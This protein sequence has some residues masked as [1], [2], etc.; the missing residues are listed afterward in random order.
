MLSRSPNPRPL[1]KAG[2][3]HGIPHLLIAQVNLLPV[4]LFP[5]C[6]IALSSRYISLQIVGLEWMRPQTPHLCHV[7]LPPSIST[8]K[9]DS[10]A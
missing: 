10:A 8:Q 2:G 5:P 9:P 1:M 3:L 7:I 6:L 4:C